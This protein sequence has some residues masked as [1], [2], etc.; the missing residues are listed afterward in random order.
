MSRNSILTAETVWLWALWCAVAAMVLGTGL[1]VLDY[2]QLEPDDH[3]FLSLLQ[4]VAAGH[5][6]FW[7][8][9]VVENR[10]DHLWWVDTTAVVRFFRPTLIASYWVD[11]AAFG[12]GPGAL[13]RTNLALHGLACGL[14][15]VLLFRLLR[16]GWIA[17]ACCLLF[18]AFTCHSEVIWYVAGRN[19]TLAAS[20]FLGALLLHGM[21]S[22]R[23]CWRWL[24][25]PCF[26]F[27]LA[28]KELTIALPLLC[29]AWDVWISR[30][31]AGVRDSWRRDRRLWWGYGLSIPAYFS[32]RWVALDSA[33]GS[34]LVY[35][36]FV[37]PSHPGFVMHVLT[38]LR[39]Y[40]ENLCL[41]Q[42]TP[43]FL[44][45]D[46]YG[47][48]TSTAGSLVVV[49]CLLATA[50]WLRRDRRTWLAATLALA[51]WLPTSFVYITERYLYLPSVA[52]AVWAG[53]VV[54]R[55][56]PRLRVGF[57]VVLLVW[58]SHQASWLWRKNLDISHRPREAYALRE[59]LRHAQDSL[60]TAK[61]VC[62]LDF[63]GDPIHAQFAEAQLR[64][65]L[66]RP[67]LR[68]HVLS[69]WPM[70]QARRAG[71]QVARIDANT[72]EV[73]TAEQLMEQ[74]AM[75]FPGTPFVPGT[76]VEREQLGF[77]V[78]VLD[79]DGVHARRLRFTMPSPLSDYTF[80]RWVPPA[81]A[82]P[83]TL[84][85][86]LMLAGRLAVLRP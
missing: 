6:S 48:F 65:H 57:G 56:G 1:C 37:L 39:N 78:E 51:T 11:V 16:A 2:P 62:L 47:A 83:G 53:L 18:A 12:G 10:W 46:Q 49:A 36:Y 15:V 29:L 3:R 70:G 82:V 43:P 17:A 54:Q 30:R 75:L 77:R 21:P 42:L 45:P 61:T 40:L 5:T 63:P 8:A 66:A 67:D 59:L 60:L 81:Q 13:L 20:A 68:V 64:V 79:G 34:Q 19:E 22:Q 4:E 44:R 26:V 35:P 9:C 58:I 73:E 24:A 25:V 72:F 14:V 74:A 28:A 7:Q 31:C 86:L 41:G 55:A 84:P 33:A 32:V 71:L 76:V 23:G 85:A 52:L 80:V 38:G 50:V 27:A 69:T